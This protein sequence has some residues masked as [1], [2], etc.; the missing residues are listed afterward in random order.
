MLELTTTGESVS[1]PKS[2]S[3]P[4]TESD[5]A[6]LPLPFA[7]PLAFEA[8]L[9]TEKLKEELGRD[10]RL[11]EGGQIIPGPRRA[12]VVTRPE[13]R[14][15]LSSVSYPELIRRVLWRGISRKGF[16]KRLRLNQI[17]NV[18]I[19]IDEIIIIIRGLRR[20]LKLME[21]LLL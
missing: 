12:G 18:R 1:F 21:L 5:W 10:W 11:S 13:R 17:G 16:L 3:V 14:G 4:A 8:R 7:W 9:L 20:L 19:E 2:Y 15:L 6:R